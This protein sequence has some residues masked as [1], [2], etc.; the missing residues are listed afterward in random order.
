MRV[1]TTIMLFGSLLFAASAEAAEVK[2][3]SAGAVR[4]VITEVSDI[5]AKET[6]HS[7]KG[8][9]GTVG[10]VRG[11]LSA[12]EPADVVIATDVAID[13]MAILGLV[14]AGTR[15]DVA[16]AGV[17][18]GVREGAPRPDIS[19]PEA[20][21]Q[22]LLAARSIVYVDPAQGAT[23]GIHFASVLQRLGI[24]DQVKGKSILWPGGYAAEAVQKGQAEIV[25]HQI[26]E[27][28]PVKGVTFVGPLPRDL[29]KVTIYSA[30]LAA[31]AAAPEAARAFIAFLTTPPIKAKFAAAGLDYQEALSEPTRIVWNS[32]RDPQL[33]RF[34]ETSTSCYAEVDAQYPPSGTKG[35]R[36]DSRRQQYWFSCMKTKGYEPRE[37]SGH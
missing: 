5:F 19:T 20:F 28:L 3:L 17:G 15:T 14:V 26:S 36:P 8:T 21:K 32:P 7:V 11:K 31:N 24:A 13:E 10:V 33:A 2:V 29:Q 27:I 34:Q 35:A 1:T 22:T 37:V 4:A 6:G 12:G 25:V 18:V 23:S 16:R 9:F 30:G